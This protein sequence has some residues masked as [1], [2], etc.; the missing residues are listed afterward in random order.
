MAAGS[1]LSQPHDCQLSNLNLQLC[2]PEQGY[3]SGTLPVSHPE[4]VES[5]FPSLQ[6]QPGGPQPS[7]LNP[8]LYLSSLV[9]V[10]ETFPAVAPPSTGIG[11]PKCGRFRQVELDVTNS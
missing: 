9:Q 6:A 1:L 7:D 8:Q 5:I 11:P 4:N 10:H 3:P 2:S